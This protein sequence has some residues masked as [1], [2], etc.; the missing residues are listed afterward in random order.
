M[1]VIERVIIHENIWKRTVLYFWR[2][3]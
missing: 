2:V 3:W 1:K